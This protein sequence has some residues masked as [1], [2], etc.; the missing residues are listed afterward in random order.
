[1]HLLL[2]RVAIVLRAVLRGEE[3][4]ILVA[5]PARRLLPTPTR[6]CRRSLLLEGCNARGFIDIGLAPARR[7]APSPHPSHRPFARLTPS[8]STRTCGQTGNLYEEATRQFR[9][10][11]RQQ[12]RARSHG[13]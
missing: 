10:Q 5:L 2:G 3:A 8:H 9:V 1:M 4:S 6:R 11:L 12:Q 7:E 13:R